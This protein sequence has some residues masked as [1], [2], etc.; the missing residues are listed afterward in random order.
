VCF[1][2]EFYQSNSLSAAVFY[3]LRNM[4]A[5]GDLFDMFNFDRDQQGDDNGDNQR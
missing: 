4:P 1:V 5:I 2:T 3:V